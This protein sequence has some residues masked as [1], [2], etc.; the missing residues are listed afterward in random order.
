[1]LEK[2]QLT[3][4]TMNWQLGSNDYGLNHNRDFDD[5]SS[6]STIRLQVTDSPTERVQSAW[7]DLGVDTAA[8]QRAGTSQLSQRCLNSELRQPPPGLL[9]GVHL[10][11]RRTSDD[12]V[13]RRTSDDL[14]P[15]RTSDDLAP[16]RT[17]DDLMP[18][19]TSDDLMP[20]R[21]SDDL[22]PRRTPDDLIP[23]R[24]SDDLMP[25]R[26]SDDLM[27]RRT[28][29]DLIPT[30][31]SD[32]LMPRTSDDL[33]PR[34]TSDD[35]MPRTEH[36]A[37]MKTVAAD[38]RPMMDTDDGRSLSVNRRHRPSS[39]SSSTSSAGLLVTSFLYKTVYS[40]SLIH[41]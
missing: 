5:A 9:G 2:L 37:L 35:L 31:T 27:P 32:D 36:I 40:L 38:G 22:V 14:L 17:S 33:V 24:T 11:R 13:P 4:T 39:A 19:R 23:R 8:W 28:S 6:D 18:R 15:R 41:I 21:T 25:R 26:T 1:M 12:L 16:R 3:E 29:D 20:R 30:R 34:R 7:T 10:D